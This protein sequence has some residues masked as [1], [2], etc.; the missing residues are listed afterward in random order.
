M[1]QEFIIPQ[2]RRAEKQTS[3]VDFAFERLGV[4]FEQEYKA[5][6]KWLTQIG[7]VEVTKD[8]DLVYENKSGELVPV[9][10][11]NDLRKMI[12]ENY[13]DRGIVDPHTDSSTILL[14]M[15]DQVFGMIYDQSALIEK[16]Y[17]KI[18]QALLV[19]VHG[20]GLV[21][22][23]PNRKKILKI[24][25]SVSEPHSFAV[26]HHLAHIYNPKHVADNIDLF[27]HM[28]SITFRR[29]WISETH[30]VVVSNLQRFSGLLEYDAQKLLDAG[31]FREAKANVASFNSRAKAI[32]IKYATS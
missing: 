5:K 22:A 20:G 27:T 25:D 28:D 10:G 14:D 7:V 24:L 4:N 2:R 18:D 16:I 11:I 13:I 19:E 26:A 6:V 30:A 21:Q 23:E 29:L 3:D 32:V 9:P 15:L 17:K 31:H 12:Q 1:L 8:G